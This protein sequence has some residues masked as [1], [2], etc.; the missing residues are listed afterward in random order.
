MYEPTAWA[1]PAEGI[2]L[3][4]MDRVCSKCQRDLVDKNQWYGLPWDLRQAVRSEFAC[5][6]GARG[7]CNSC[8]SQLRGNDPDQLA[9]HERK[10]LP[11]DIFA[12]EYN[13][14][15]EQGVTDRLIAE[16]LGLYRR[17]RSMPSKRM[18]TFYKALKRAKDR[19]LIT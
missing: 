19:G 4:L 13:L 17:H 6:P 14:L 18:D 15:H 1:K 5:G 3:K 11:L 7:L 8:Y 16:K 12:E 2:T 9:D 10:T